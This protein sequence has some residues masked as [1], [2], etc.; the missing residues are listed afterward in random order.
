M[1]R[2][3][4]IAG[5]AG[6]AAAWPFAAHAQP[7]GRPPTVGFLGQSTPAVESQRISAFVERLR[8]LGWTEGRTIAIEVRWADGRTKRYAEIATEFARLKVDII[9][10]AGTPSV[11][12]RQGRRQP[13]SRSSLR[14]QRTRSAT[15]SSQA[16]RDPGVI[17]LAYRSWGLI[18]PEN[19]SN[20]CA[21][22]FQLSTH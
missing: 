8:E 15:R 12:L 18:L 1:R 14:Q 2:R 22:L 7:A 6:S 16:W 19:D 21:T 17:S 3:D 20:S 9:V 10:T 11:S 4:F 5:I 13:A